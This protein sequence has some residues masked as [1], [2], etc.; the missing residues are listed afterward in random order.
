[1]VATSQTNTPD[2]T[3]AVNLHAVIRRLLDDRA[4]LKMQ[5]AEAREQVAQLQSSLLLMDAEIART[6]ECCRMWD[7]TL[8]DRAEIGPLMR[9]AM[10]A[11]GGDPANLTLFE[12]A[13]WMAEAMIASGR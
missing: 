8:A 12:I 6:M 11:W 13:R 4:A 9:Q 1:M 7:K 5:L 3:V 2:D 10:A